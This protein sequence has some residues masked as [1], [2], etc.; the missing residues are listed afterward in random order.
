MTY[1][2]QL[3]AQ[4][5]YLLFA[6]DTKFYRPMKSP[7]DWNHLQSGAD[8]TQDWCTTNST[9]LSIS[10][11]KVISFQEPLTYWL[12]RINLVNPL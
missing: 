9:K 11:T 2:M 8:S 10:K 6:Y 4:Y 7:D 1:V 12:T 5:T 3:I